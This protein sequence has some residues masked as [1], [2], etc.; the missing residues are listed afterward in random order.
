M[1]IFSSAMLKRVSSAIKIQKVWRGY[2]LRSKHEE[3]LRS[4]LKLQ[5]AAIIIQRWIRRQ[6]VERRKEFMFFTT[7]RLETLHDNC[8]Y[9][10]V[11]DYLDLVRS[12]HNWMKPEEVV[13]S[14]LEQ[15]TRL[16]LDREAH[17]LVF[18]WNHSALD[19][20]IIDNIRVGK[21]P[22]SKNFYRKSIGLTEDQISAKIGFKSSKHEFCDISH[23][24][25]YETKTTILR[26]QSKSYLEIKCASKAEARFRTFILKLITFGLQSK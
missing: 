15:G 17:L 13:S 4:I 3:H 5:R 16:Y 26:K 12:H 6:P 10:E 18:D 20:G 22:F 23:L 2:Q 11:N 9:V 1:H 24:F 21:L 8:F 25:H 7:K 14:F 19:R